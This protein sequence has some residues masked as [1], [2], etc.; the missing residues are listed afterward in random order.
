MQP[1]LAEP[2][3]FTPGTSL[4]S[5]LAR[6]ANGPAWRTGP[7]GEPR[8]PCRELPGDGRPQAAKAAAM[9]ARETK[10]EILQQVIHQGLRPISSLEWSSSTN[11]YGTAVCMYI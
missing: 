9:D 1:Y 3:Y 4:S 8:P 2:E 10:P 11:V 5:C 7:P 6:L